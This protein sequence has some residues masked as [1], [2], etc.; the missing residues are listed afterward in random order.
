MAHIYISLGSNIQRSYHV[1]QGLNALS[2]EFSTSIDS[3]S[4]SSLF[5]SKAIGFDG[6]PF[7]NMVIGIKT[8]YNI[9]Q[10]AKILRKIEFAHGRKHDA[11]K[12]SPRHLD[13]DLLLYN[14]VITDKPA[15]IPR[16]EMI[17]NAFILWPL[18]E[19]APELEH[20]VLKECYQVLWQNYDKSKQQLKIIDPC[21]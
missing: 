13:L 1:K 14:D 4:L 16:D 5:E 12:F 15:Q 7:Y 21:W 17:T 9:D 19:I 10:V 18:S 3:F 11:K 20:P 2:N 6:T 8:S